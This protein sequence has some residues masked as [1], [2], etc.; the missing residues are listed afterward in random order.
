M[1]Q[2]DSPWMWALTLA[3]PTASHMVI[4]NVIE[5]QLMGDDLD[6]HPITILLALVFWSLV[7]GIVGAFVSVPLTAVMKVALEQHQTTRGV[8]ELLAGR[9]GAPR[10]A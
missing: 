4:G 9:V 1:A 10:E 3:L 8:A 2:F 6:L 5:P 7:W